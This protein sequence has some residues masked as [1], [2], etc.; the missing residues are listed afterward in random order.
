MAPFSVGIDT[1][2]NLLIVDNY[3]EVIRK[4]TP[5][6]IISTVAGNGGQGY[7]GVG[8]PATNATLCSPVGMAFDGAGN[9]FFA[10]ACNQV[11]YKVT[12]AGIIKTA[13]GHFVVEQFSGGF[14]GDGGPATSVNFPLD[15][16]ADQAGNL[17]IA[18]DNNR[19]VR[20]VDTTGTITTIVGN[21]QYAFGADGGPAASA[22]FN[23]PSGLAFD[24]A[25]N[26]FV[27]DTRN[28]R[29]RKITPAGVISTVAGNG[30][31]GVNSASQAFPGEGGPA[32]S[33]ALNYP[34]G[35]AVDAAGNLFIADTFAS[36]IRKVSPSGIIT[37]VATFAIDTAPFRV[38]V[39]QAG[40]LFVANG[41]SGVVQK[42]T[43]LGFVS[44]VAGNGTFGYSGDGGPATSA[45]LNYPQGLALDAAGNIFI[46]DSGNNVV[47]K[48][49]AAGII[50]TIAGNGTAAY[51]G[52]GGPATG[53]S[54]TS[55][56][57]LAIDAAG[58][59]FIADQNSAVRMVTPQGIISTVA[60]DGMG[61]LSGDGGLATSAELDILPDPSGESNNSSDVAV[62]AAG[63][64]YISDTNNNRIRKVLVA[65]PTVTVAPAA[66]QFSAP[67]G[68]APAAVQTLSVTSSITGTDNAPFVTI[69]VSSGF[70]PRL[71]QVT[72]D[73]TNLAPGVNIQALLARRKA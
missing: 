72:A 65:A 9:F 26:L 40:N 54:L 55:P 46:S 33:A 70:S 36:A 59:L 51:S 24:A 61:G 37:T 35:V 62:D 32:T 3:A 58:N 63:N 38:K 34:L 43:P 18:D 16:A 25:G 47:R 41:N 42:V 6:G 7:S 30:S 21:G 2:G 27:A 52:D 60:G 8:G 13:A 48:V 22:K 28:N 4:V 64:L 17:F 5:A 69:D 15:L 66:M 39:D 19:R 23:I 49:T 20:K 67:S 56:Q 1:A 68:G 44:T 29:I 10:D 53:A 11:I 12:P 14:S 71:I 45:A 31:S 57:G 73:P 50:T